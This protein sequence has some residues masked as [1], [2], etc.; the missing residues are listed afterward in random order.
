M[1]REENFKPLCPGFPGS[2]MLPLCPFGPK[3]PVSPNGPPRPGWPE[4]QAA[5]ECH[6]F[7]IQ[8]K[9]MSHSVNF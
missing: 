4:T 5:L 3:L 8:H 1:L 2:P 9:R 7:F 6:H